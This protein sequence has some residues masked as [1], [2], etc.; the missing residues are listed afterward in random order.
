MEI[1]DYDVP[2]PGEEEVLIEVK[3]CGI[4]G[5][6]VHMAEADK[7][8]YIL[9]PGLTGFPAIMGHE[10]SG[11]VVKAG[12]NARNK[13][14]NNRLLRAVSTE[15]MLGAASANRARM[16]IRTSANNWTKLDLTSTEPTRNILSSPRGLSGA[17]PP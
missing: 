2:E 13:R 16:D 6:D 4:C 17:W 9:Y 10:L 15:E 11:V 14:T 8:G 7:D 5:S 1:R 3:A 12:K